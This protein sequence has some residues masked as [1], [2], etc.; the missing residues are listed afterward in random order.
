MKETILITGS[1]SGIG[2]A[3]VKLFLDNGYENIIGLDLKDSPINSPAYTHH[4]CDVSKK[5]QLPNIGN[6]SILV[7]NAGSQSTSNSFHGDDLSTNLVGTILCTEKYG[8]HENIKSIINQAS[9][10]AH[11]GAEFPEYA[12]SK[13]GVLAYTKWTA[14]E[15]A[16]YEGVC[17]SLSFG[18]VSTDLNKPVMEDSDLWEDIMKQTPLKKWVTPYEAAQWIYFMAVVNRSCTGQD[19]IIDNGEFYNHQ[20][21]WE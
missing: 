5:D 14:K 2:L 4:K 6:V 11:N 13:G 16:K 12:A 19:I 15:I 17:N 9:V 20:F 3:T 7:N 1:S 10:S 8:L 18:G 21:V